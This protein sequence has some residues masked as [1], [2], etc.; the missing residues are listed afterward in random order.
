MVRDGWFLD[1]RIALV[2]GQQSL[3]QVEHQL[4]ELQEQLAILLELPTCTQ[5]DLIEPPL[6][7]V[8]ITCADDAVA[9]SGER[10]LLRL[11]YDFE[12]FVQRR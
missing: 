6:P 11:R 5:F 2:E 1:A 3:Q 8:P 9:R 4:A 12:G 10:V 7:I